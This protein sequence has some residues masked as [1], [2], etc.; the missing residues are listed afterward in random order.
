MD[1]D[2][3][4]VVI[5]GGT[6]G[7]GLATAMAA[8]DH[9]ARVT[10]ASHRKENVESACSE[11]P[12][13]TTGYV[14]DAADEHALEDFFVKVGEF[15]HL[16]FTAGGAL[17][18]GEI[19]KISTGEAM[20]AFSVRFWGAWLAAKYAR[21]NILDGG[22]IVLSSGI[23]GSRPQRGGT[24]IASVCGAIEALTRALAVEFA[25]VRVNAV[26]AG[27]VNTNLWSDIDAPT[28][29]AIFDRVRQELPVGRIGEAA[30][31]AKSHLYLMSE[32]F[33]TGTVLTVDGGAFLK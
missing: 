14:V 26:S 4:H 18:L 6:S 10:I 19:D 13:D 2:A 25:P 22:S 30:D 21:R 17:L 23:A 31:I 8:A 11:L 24:V 27:V 9:G 29:A 20:A 3:K 1:F 5:L 32:R 12:A 15:D 28:Q 16:V 7:I 33:T